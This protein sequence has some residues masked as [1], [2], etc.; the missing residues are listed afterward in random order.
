MPTFRPVPPL[1]SRPDFPEVA[2]RWNEF[3]TTDPKADSAGST[4]IAAVVPRPGCEP[5]AKPPYASGHH[6]DFTPVVDDILRWAETHL[7]LGDAIPYYY[8]EFAADH[9]TSLLGVDLKFPDPKMGGWPIHTITDWEDADIR[10]RPDCYWWERTVEFVEAIRS[11]GDGMIMLASPTLV[12]NLDCLVAL[13]GSQKVLLDLAER[14]EEI[15]EALGKVMR[16]YRDVL[17]AF[18]SLYDYDTWGS[19]NRHGMWCRGRI[20]VVQSDF[21]CMLSPEMFDRFVLPWISRE[22]DELD[23]VEY[24]LD[25]PDA[26][27]HTPKLCGIPKLDIMQWVP[28]AGKGEKQDWL[29]LYEEFHRLGKGQILGGNPERAKLYLEKFAGTRLFI[30]IG[31]L[32][33]SADEARRIIDGLRSPKR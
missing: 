23:Q 8:T 24:H 32:P 2:A 31:G 18:A 12:G 29:P 22:M 10:F 11:R 4:L 5:V 21:S 14:P 1:S 20:N 28:G 3:W 15:E 16:A 7:F 25:G 17:D 9:F 26:I 30:N 19:I 33:E 27:R 6:G 13:A